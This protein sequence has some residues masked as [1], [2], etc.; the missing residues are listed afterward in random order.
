MNTGPKKNLTYAPS[1]WKPK[2][3]G[4]GGTGYL[5]TIDDKITSDF[6]KYVTEHVLDNSY[7]QQILMDEFGLTSP[8]QVRE[9]LMDGKYG[10]FHDRAFNIVY[11]NS[12]IAPIEPIDG[13]RPTP[14]DLP[15]NLPTIDRS[16]IPQAYFDDNNSEFDRKD[17]KKDSNYIPYNWMRLAPVFDNMRSVLE[18]NEPDY[19]LSR[20]IASLYKP[21]DYRPIGQHMSYTPIDQYNLMNRAN[22]ANNTLLGVFANNASTPAARNFY[23]L[24]A[25]QNYQQGL[26]NNYIQGMQYNDAKHEHALAFNNNLDMSNEQNRLNIEG[27]NRQAYTNLMSMAYQLADQERLAVEEARNRNLQH[28]AENIGE[29]G[30]ELTSYDLISHMRHLGYGPFASYYT[31]KEDEEEA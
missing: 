1:D 10:K 9:Y 23:A 25:N 19:T 31:G 16:T 15:L 4:T 22:Q 6:Y 7:Y 12:N 2:Y 29:V 20:Q 14:K 3:K 11:G 27:G 18:Q 28:L 5:G 30:K 8:D 17:K 26:A 24:N 13:I 21:I